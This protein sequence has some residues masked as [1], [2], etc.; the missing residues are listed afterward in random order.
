M[1]G[2]RV[3]HAAGLADSQVGGSREGFPE[4]HWRMRRGSQGM[5]AAGDSCGEM[6]MAQSAA[7]GQG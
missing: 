5:E 1:E 2:Q 6:D 7:A 4:G 3:A